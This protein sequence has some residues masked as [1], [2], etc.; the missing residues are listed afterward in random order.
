ME[1]E[2][3]LG[4][5]QVFLK[6][7]QYHRSLLDDILQLEKMGD[8]ALSSRTIRYVTGV[9]QDQ[10]A[11]LITNLVSGKTQTL[12]QPQGVWTIGRDRQLAISIPDRHLS[13]YHAV[14]QYIKNQGFYLIDLNSTNGSFVNGEP[15]QG[16]ILLKDGDR[17]RLSSL[18]FCFFLCQ[19]TQTLGETPPNILPQL[20]RSI[21]NPKLSAPKSIKSP[22]SEIDLDK[23]P[24]V[25][26]VREEEQT[27]EFLEEL[28]HLEE[29]KIK[30]SIPKLSPLQQSEILDRFF[31]RQIQKASESE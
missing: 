24:L 8:Q 26:Q 28:A 25:K 31:S 16:R 5:Y 27:S 7:Y 23:L 30:S 29:P 20:Q 11:Y 13:R 22:V 14:I 15:L 1:I 17:I 2:Q 4:L 21:L 19:N 12:Y 6:V 3:R 18:A 9:C 10:Q